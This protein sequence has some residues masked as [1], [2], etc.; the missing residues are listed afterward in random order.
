[1]ATPAARP[2]GSVID[3]TEDDDDDVQGNKKDHPV[4][5][6]IGLWLGK[7]CIV[8]VGDPLG[9]AVVLWLMLIRNPFVS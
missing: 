3:L 9:P 8:I 4:L 2:K 6:V 5:M 1:M 7:C